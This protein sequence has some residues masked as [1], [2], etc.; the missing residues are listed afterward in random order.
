MDLLRKEDGRPPFVL[1][2]PQIAELNR[3]ASNCDHSLA[4]LMTV[5]TLV[6]CSAVVLAGVGVRDFVRRDEHLIVASPNRG[7]TRVA[8]GQAAMAAVRDAIA[9]RTAGLLF[10]EAHDVPIEPDSDAVAYL[11]ELIAEDGEGPL[12]FAFTF[13]SVREGVFAAMVDD[14][15]PH[16]VAEAQAGLRHMTDGHISDTFM[17]IQQKAASDWWAAQLGVP[18]P[19]TIDVVRS[20]LGRLSWP[21]APRGPSDDGEDCA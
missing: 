10:G 1:T 19:A 2:T 16:H 20:S 12:P 6:P 4:R 13:R 18:V 15:V 21:D 7:R 9:G 5:A 11:Q 8:L 3:R 14:G 17:R